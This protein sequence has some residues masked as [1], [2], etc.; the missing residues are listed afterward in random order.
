MK[1]AVIGAGI[2][3][4]STARTLCQR[5]HKVTLYERFGLFHEQGSSHGASR[6]VR[7]AY[8]DTFY[9]E[10]MAEAYPL[11]HELEEDANERLLHE[12]GLLYYGSDGAENLKSVANGLQELSV[13]FEI[14]DTVSVR[15]KLP[16]L[17]LAKDEI[18]IWTP[19][20]GWVNAARALRATYNLAVSTGLQV[21]LGRPADLHD[22]SGQFDVVLV[23]AGSWTPDF[24][25]APVTVTL[26]TYAYTE[27]SI[28]GPVWIEDSKENPYGFPA[29]DI[30]QKIGLHKAGPTIDPN[31]DAREPDTRWLDEIREIA[32]RRFGIKEPVLKDSKTCLYTTTWNE[33][34]LLGRI[35]SNVFFASAC[36]G[37]GFKMGPW[38]G[39]LLADFAEGKD[40]PQ[41]HP[42]FNFEAK[43]ANPR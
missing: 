35:T 39:R 43:L 40:A 8:P 3:G 26:Q 4:L 15:S 24:V 22:L 5:G 9:T 20:A 30:G 10:C 34:F 12:C 13:P 23:A 6:I 2:V 36:S 25:S 41:N 38:I 1:I 21:I 32:H 11:W 33:D 27:S 28:G 31:D 7:R 37:H 18:A 16:E 19:E 17:N 42:R 14:L 29:D